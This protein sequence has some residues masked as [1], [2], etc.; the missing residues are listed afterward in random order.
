MGGPSGCGR[1]QFAGHTPGQCRLPRA[2]CDV[3]ANGFLAYHRVRL[4]DSFSGVSQVGPVSLCS[5]HRDSSISAT[6]KFSSDTAL[7]LMC[8][9]CGMF[10]AR[11]I[12]QTL[13]VVDNSK[14]EKHFSAP[15]SETAR[16]AIDA[17]WIQA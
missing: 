16:P 10:L 1:S 12:S 14:E 17:I 2:N 15:S 3:E 7:T 6:R 4:G 9:G 8:G 11:S 13:G 5:L